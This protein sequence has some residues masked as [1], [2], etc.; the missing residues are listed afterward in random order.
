MASTEDYQEPDEF[1]PAKR[2]RL[3]AALEVTEE[4]QEEMI[5]DGDWDSIY[6]A[7][8]SPVKGE[9]AEEDVQESKGV[10]TEQS[11]ERSLEGTAIIPDASS[12]ASIDDGSPADVFH[13]GNELVT[14]ERH[15]TL[16]DE[17]STTEVVQ[18]DLPVEDTHVEG[19]VDGRENI[20]EANHHGLS[21]ADGPTNANDNV[22]V[23][24]K[25]DEVADAPAEEPPQNKDQDGELQQKPEQDPEFLEAAAA[26]KD[27][28]QAEWQFNSSDAES[29]S[30]SDSSSDDSSD[31][32]DSASEGG[33]ELLDAATAAKMLMA[34][35]GED[36]EDKKGIKDGESN[37]PRTANE[38]KDVVITKPDVIVTEDMKITFLGYIDLSAGNIVLIKAAT[39]GEYQVL[40]AGS[41]LCKENREVIGAVADTLGKVPEPIYSVA[42][43]N[44]KELKEAELGFGSKVYYVDSHS[45]FVFTQPLKN[46]KGTDASNIH[47]EEVGEDEAEFSDDEKEAEYKRQKKL[48]KRGGRGGFSRSAFNQ[49]R[50]SYTFGAPGHDSGQTYVNGSDIPKR[51]AGTGLKYDEDDDDE[52]YKPLKRP[53]NLSQLMA[54]GGPPPRPPMNNFDRGRGKGRGDR[55]FGRGRGR[56]G[57]DHRGGRGGRGGFG[58]DRGRG[59]FGQQGGHRGLAH[60]FPDQHNDFHPDGRRQR[61]RTPRQSSPPQQKQQQQ[62]RHPPQPQYPQP[63]QQTSYPF[64]GYNFQYGA[65]AP[66]SQPQQAWPAPQQQ[67]A[68]QQYTQPQNPAAGFPAA[69]AYVNPN[70]WQNP[71]Q[72]P[73]YG[74]QFQQPSDQQMPNPGGWTQQQLMQ[75]WQAMQAYQQQQQQLQQ[76]G[77]QQGNSQ[78]GQQ[79]PNL[80]DVLKQLGAGQQ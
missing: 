71:N 62:A 35:D 23:S 19:V 42:F 39:H 53:D 22:N 27:N 65:P 5:D 11:T 59:G 33:Y 9:G 44:E 66:A 6:G 48:A 32:S 78:Q 26:Q 43:T 75:S 69:G 36:G 29:D 16:Q 58:N 2:A 56:G 8:D 13:A 77:Q 7:T 17:M 74:Q 79:P 68:Q 24:V 64:N 4:V 20:E 52:F 25:P 55:G 63:T 61:S 54:N 12:V 76:Q 46:L 31:D 47:D 60:S 73:N 3:D 72:N 18:V 14:E 57:F 30:D 51:E 21:S 10:S 80:A 1:R 41:V 28:P 38:V 34:G 45:T 50:E 37:Q 15:D 67:Y 49:D 40:E 70:F